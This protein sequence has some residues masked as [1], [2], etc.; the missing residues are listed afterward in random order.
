MAAAAAMKVVG[1]AFTS[2]GT[3]VFGGMA[4][5]MLVGG[6]PRNIRDYYDDI[7]KDS[8]LDL[9]TRSEFAEADDWEKNLCENLHYFTTGKGINFSSSDKIIYNSNNNEIYDVFLDSVRLNITLPKIKIIE[10]TRKE[11]IPKKVEKPDKK[12]EENEEEPVKVDKPDKEKDKENNKKEKKIEY[13]EIEIKEYVLSFE[14]EKTNGKY[15][16]LKE[17]KVLTEKQFNNLKPLLDEEKGVWKLKYGGKKIS[18]LLKMSKTSPDSQNLKMMIST[19]KSKYANWIRDFHTFLMKENIEIFE[20][21]LE[22]FEIN[23]KQISKMY[24]LK[25]VCNLLGYVSLAAA[26]VGYFFTWWIW[27]PLSIIMGIIGFIMTRI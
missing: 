17:K 26:I 12:K 18:A 2:I 7:R 21:D 14:P 6:L 24:F 27:V 22:L 25:I 11:K 8:S 16:E 10:T 4:L 3:F 9:K 1:D 5:E 15:E 13:K 20:N 23:I 19:F